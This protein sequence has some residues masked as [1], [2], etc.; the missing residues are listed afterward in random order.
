MKKRMKIWKK[1]LTGLIA[2]AGIMAAA[3]PVFAENTETAEMSARYSFYENGKEWSGDIKDNTC[4]AV[5]NGSYVTAMKATLQNQPAGMTGTIAYQV[6]LSG[7]GWIEWQE[8][9]VEAGA[10]SGDKPLEAVKMKLTGELAEHYDVYYSVYQ[11]GSWTELVMNGE[12]A[13]VE[14]HGQRV[15]GL[16]V[17]VTKKGEVPAEPIMA[18]KADPTKPM[19]AL[20]FDDGPSKVTARILD[21][22]EANDARATFYM[23]GNR[24]N[25]YPDA[26]RRMEALGCEFGNH[27]WAHTYL[28]KLS[29]QGIH[30]TLNQTSGTLQNI[31]GK[32]TTTVRPPGGYVNDSVRQALASYGISAVMW[33]IDTLDWKTRNAQSTINTVLSQVKDGDVILMHDLY[34][35]TADAAAV[36]IPELKNRG[37][38]LVTV[39]E[40]AEYRGGMQAGGVYYSFRP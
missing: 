29:A 15:A 40:L 13:G 16:R 21:S 25:S 36:L 22:L 10:S 34:S 18:G 27:T 4:E 31:V 1:L 30:D 38:Q 35:A 14:G 5:P 8:N 26:V 20:T 23:V 11:G 9:C 12:T 6:N 33:S 37:Y 3:F 32:R 17:A 7:S 28:T 19:I 2:A 24:I 39:S